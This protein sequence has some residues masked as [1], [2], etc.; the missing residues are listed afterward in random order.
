MRIRTTIVIAFGALMFAASSVWACSSLGPNKHIGTVMSIDEAKNTFTLLDAQS[1]A[2]IT[3]L[4]NAA[5]L[6]ELA[7]ATGQVLVDY[8]LD[9]TQLRATLIR[10]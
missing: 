8:E 4:A 7:S 1:N 5:I 9:G 6:G 10:F 2:P 3:F